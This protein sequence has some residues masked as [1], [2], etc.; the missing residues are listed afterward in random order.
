MFVEDILDGGIT[1]FDPFKRQAVAQL[2][3]SPSG[4]LQAKFRDPLYFLGRCSERIRFWNGRE[5]LQ[6]FN[7]MGLKPALV[8]V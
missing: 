3:A 2:V 8:L 6:A 7:P 4:M 5:I 1:D